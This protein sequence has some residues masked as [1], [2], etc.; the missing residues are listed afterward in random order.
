M[1]VPSTAV[2]SADYRPGRHVPS[3]ERNDTRRFEERIH[4]RFKPGSSLQH[5]AGQ[6]PAK[7]KT[8]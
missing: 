2:R 7:R 6:Y 5:A 4:W 1:P 8:S 3:T